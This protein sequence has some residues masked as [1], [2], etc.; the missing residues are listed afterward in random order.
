MGITSNALGEA[1][2]DPFEV[3]IERILPGGVGL[4]HAEGKTLFVALA[5]PGDVARVRVDRVRGKVAF[6]TIEE[7][8]SP[9][10]VRIEPP[11]R[12]FGT[13]GG[14]DFQQLDYQAQ[15]DAKVAIIRD[16][17]R[18]IAHVENLD[19]A[20]T[21]S[22]RQWQ[23]RSRVNWQFNAETQALGFFERGSHQVCDIAECAVLVPELQQTLMRLRAAIPSFPD[24]LDELEAVA[25]DQGVS[26]S[27]PLPGFSATDISRKVAEETYHFNSE[28]FFQINDGILAA[29]VTE[30][31]HN[32]RGAKAMDLYCGVGLF[33]VALARRFTFVGGVEA[34][35]DAALFARR[36]LQFASLPNGR[37]AI[38]DV[39]DWLEANAGPLAPVDLLVID[40]PRTG[41][42][43]HVIDGILNLKPKRITYVS[44]DPATL[45]RDLKALLAAGFDLATVAAFDMFPQTHHVETV[46]KLNQAK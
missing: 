14:C 42:E 37:I 16:C 4:A 36:N 21:P 46:V 11:C 41:V 3:T 2:A 7:I 12:Y 27:T 18:R 38:H 44:C 33:T 17:L 13:C 25:G 40:P 28:S 5:A 24:E 45:A 23:Y 35:P 32:E 15:L 39:G 8:L 1:M 30:V 19:I 43:E 10:P 31:T 29:L 34:N 9:S 6:A 22:P 26:L 20:I